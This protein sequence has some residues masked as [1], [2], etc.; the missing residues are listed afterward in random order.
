M[1]TFADDA[2][3]LW[4]NGKDTLKISAILSERYRKQIPEWRIHRIITRE[5][6]ERLGFTTIEGG[7]NGTYHQA[8]R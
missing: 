5:R 3:D 4:R 1:K 8:N 7:L 2:I 6:Q